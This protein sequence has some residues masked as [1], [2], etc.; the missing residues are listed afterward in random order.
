MEI[1]LC[2]ICNQSVYD[3]GFG[4]VIQK[5]RIQG[6]KRIFD[7]A[8]KRKDNVFVKIEPHRNL[9]ESFKHNFRYHQQ[10]Y[11]NYTSPQNIAYQSTDSTSNIQFTVKERSK[12]SFDI[13]KMCFICNKQG[14][15]KKR[16]LYRLVLELEKVREAKF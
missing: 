14:T 13:R 12:S 11:K 7:A 9:L 2:I 5:P 16:S 4:K 3:D 15:L 1:H 6:I 10:C 8:D